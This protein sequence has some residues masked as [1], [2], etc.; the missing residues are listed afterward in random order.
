MA[1]PDFQTIQPQAPSL[2]YFFALTPQ[3]AIRLR[4]CFNPP[5]DTK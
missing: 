5:P 1:V 2:R 3:A 4:L